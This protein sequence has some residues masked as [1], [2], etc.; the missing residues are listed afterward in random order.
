VKE[1]TH[2]ALVGSAQGSRSK[3]EDGRQ[4]RQKRSCGV[5]HSLFFELNKALLMVMVSSVKI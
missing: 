3:M 2:L 4:G 1:A 5:A